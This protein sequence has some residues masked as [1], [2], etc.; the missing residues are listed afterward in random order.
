MT[1]LCKARKACKNDGS[2][3]TPNAE[4]GR[5]SHCKGINYYLNNKCS[6]VS[7]S[8]SVGKVN[9]SFEKDSCQNFRYN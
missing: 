3:K 7:A 9:D 8:K 5:S 2:S 6:I 4:K 1:K